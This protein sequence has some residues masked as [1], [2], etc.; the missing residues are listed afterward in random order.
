MSAINE[1]KRMK[2]EYDKKFEEISKSLIEIRGELPEVSGLLTILF[3]LE[4]RVSSLEI[5]CS[6]DGI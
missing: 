6:G 1:L 5:A 4:K 3:E 2:S